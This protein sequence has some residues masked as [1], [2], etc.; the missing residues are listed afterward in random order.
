MHITS[1][2]SPRSYP[3]MRGKFLTWRFSHVDEPSMTV[4][5]L[6]RGISRNP[7]QLFDA[8]RCLGDSSQA[9]IY[10]PPFSGSS[11]ICASALRAA[12]ASADLIV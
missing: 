1:R 2:S 8:K 4:G 7:A 3:S 11:S 5:L 12:Q 9:G 6:P 10:S